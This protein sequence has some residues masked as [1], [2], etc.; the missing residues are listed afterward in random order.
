MIS[1]KGYDLLGKTKTEG[2][3][4][5]W[6]SERFGSIV[7]SAA[8]NTRT[9][10]GGEP[11]CAY[12]TSV[13][14]GCLLRV[15]G[16]ACV[17]CRT[18]KAIPFGGLLTYKEIAKQNIFMVLSDIHCDDHPELADR[19]R[20]FAYMGQGEPGFSYSQVRL[21][22]EL[23]NKVMRRLGQTVY[24]HILATSGVPEAI[25]AF[26]DDTAHF[27]TERV[28]LHL[29][30]HACDKRWQL[31]PINNIYPMEEVIA[32]TDGVFALT[33]EKTCVGVM[34]FWNYKAQ[35]SKEAYSTTIDTVEP[36]LDML[37]PSEYRLSFCEFNPSS[38]TGESEIYPEAE[39]QAL[40]RYAR[41]RHFEAKLFSSFGREEFTA[42]GMLGGKMTEKEPSTKWM[43][44]DAIADKLII[45]SL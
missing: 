33:K 26:K 17:F 21:A 14:A 6:G 44:L 12:T 22:I 41:E 5:A 40:L 28:T 8:F 45:E 34:L 30:L 13:S 4:Y 7:E 3:R 27:F 20:E 18:G 31:M 9:K 1:I 38:E 42:C 36:L 23:T 11:V 43:K 15:L 37:N 2:I 16:K 24:R 29:S 32:Q 39:A 35:N 25:C 19:P 10:L